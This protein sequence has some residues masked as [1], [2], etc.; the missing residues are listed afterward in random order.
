MTTCGTC[1]SDIRP[2]D[3]RGTTCACGGAPVYVGDAFWLG[4][5]AARSSKPNLALGV[6]MHEAMLNDWDF[7]F[8]AATPPI[9]WSQIA[10]IIDVERQPFDEKDVIVILDGMEVLRKRPG[11]APDFMHQGRS[12]DLKL[13]DAY[14]LHLEDQDIRTLLKGDFVPDDKHRYGPHATDPYAPGSRRRRR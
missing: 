8:I 2:C 11:A 13:A 14:R 3:M 12:Y 6:A 4:Y 10:A 7:S 1:G 5:E 9:T